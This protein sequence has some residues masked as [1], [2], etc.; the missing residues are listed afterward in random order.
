[1]A[2]DSYTRSVCPKHDCL[3]AALNLVLGCLVCCRGSAPLRSSQDDPE[4]LQLCNT[5]GN[6]AATQQMLACS[7]C[8]WFSVQAESTWTINCAVSEPC[9]ASWPQPLF[10]RDDAELNRAE[11][12]VCL[13]APLL[14]SQDRPKLSRMGRGGGKNPQAPGQCLLHGPS[15]V[16]LWLEQRLR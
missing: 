5:R 12:V 2:I 16:S 4:Q 11:R 8:F 6:Q 1:M 10:T 7:A 13:T 9:G 15:I 14:S 3:L